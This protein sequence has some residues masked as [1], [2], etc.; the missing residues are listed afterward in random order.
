MGISSEVRAAMKEM[1]RKFGRQSGKNSRSEYEHLA[2]IVR[3]EKG[4]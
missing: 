2:A 3:P 4:I 1:A